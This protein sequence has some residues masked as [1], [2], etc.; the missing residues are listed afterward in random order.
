MRT[1]TRFCLTSLLLWSACSRELDG[2]KPTVSAVTP[3]VACGDQKM[4]TV[5]ISGQALSPLDDLN[6]TK[7]QLELPQ[8]T[9]TRVK[10][11]TGA[12]ASDVVT[13]PNDPTHPE[14]G[15][16]QWTSQQAMSF[17]VCP[18]GVC[19]AATPKQTDYASLPTGLYTITATNRNGHA[20]SL[21]STLT[22]VP[23]PTLDSTIPDLLCE[24]KDNTVTLSG[25]FFLRINGTI[26]TL[27]INDPAGAK[28]LTPSALDDCRPLPAATGLTLEACRKAT[29]TIPRGMFTQGT[30]ELAD[31]EPRA[32]GLPLG[33][34]LE[35]GDADLR[36][37]AQAHDRGP[38]P[39]L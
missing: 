22:I 23:L 20:A 11:I 32:G 13:V 18:P 3:Q 25:D 21:P 26:G 6:L 19:G 35:Q 15:D 38:R 8:V 30:Y 27:V 29:V 10:D 14:L 36:A 28:S 34:G 5:M 37:R 9:L 4:T 33:P 39:H 7:P 17:E 31:A 24:D 16:E 2:P 1:R 12:P